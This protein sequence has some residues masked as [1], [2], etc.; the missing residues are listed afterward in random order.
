MNFLETLINFLNLDKFFRRSAPAHG[1]KQNNP[2]NE[3]AKSPSK[4]FIFQKPHKNFRQ[5]YRKRKREGK[6]KGNNGY[7]CYA[8]PVAGE[9]SDWLHFHR[10][11]VAT[12]AAGVV[13][14]GR[15]QFV[16]LFGE[17]P[18]SQ[19]RRRRGSPGKQRMREKGAN[20]QIYAQAI[21]MGKFVMK[22]YDVI[23]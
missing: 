19:R 13:G 5:T 4:L 9:G 21:K 17:V 11:A 20:S 22:I 7:L 23:Y 12:V 6:G 1:S 18:R 15:L 2:E 14:D 10:R 8:E 16:K 3:T